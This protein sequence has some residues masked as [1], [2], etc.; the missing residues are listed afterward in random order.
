[1]D[2]GNGQIHIQATGLRGMVGSRVGEVTS[3]RFQWSDL[4]CDITDRS[5]V[6]ES[7][8]T[9]ESDVIVHFAAFTDVTKAWEQ[10]GDRDGACYQVNVQGSHN[11]AQACAKHGKYMVH[12]STDYV[13]SGDSEGPYTESDIPNPVDWYGQTKLWAEA[14]V[15]NSGCKYVILRLA[16]PFQ[17]NSRR[18]DDVVRRI[19]NQLAGD[20]LYPMF[21]DSILTPTFV[22][23]FASAVRAAIDS[24]PVGVYHAVGSTALSPY[25]LARK[26]AHVFSYD[27][28]RIRPGSLSE[29]LKTLGRPYPRYLH[30]SNRNAVSILR[31][32]FLPIDDALVT[33]R[34]QRVQNTD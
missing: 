17:A 15:Q 7:I 2:I 24:R 31:V 9:A 34:D 33:M 23:D 3:D 5:A 16:F 18:K 32:P 21:T 22:D 1:M 20:S 28:S 6:D 14:E 10:R 29:Y 25:E 4:G 26:V 11:V 27:E 12:V 19:L 30:I 13:F 8:S